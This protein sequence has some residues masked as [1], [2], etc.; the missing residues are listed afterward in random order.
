MLTFV[1]SNELWVCHCLHPVIQCSHPN[2]RYTIILEHRE[3]ENLGLFT[4]C[5]RNMMLV[6]R[7][8]VSHE[9]VPSFASLLENKIKWFTCIYRTTLLLNFSCTSAGA[10]WLFAQYAWKNSSVTFGSFLM[11]IVILSNFPSGVGAGPDGLIEEPM[12][13]LLAE[14]KVVVSA[15]TSSSQCTYSCIWLDM[16]GFHAPPKAR[17][18]SLQKTGSIR[19]MVT[20]HDS[21]VGW[22]SS[23]QFSIDRI[24]GSSA[25]VVLQRPWNHHHANWN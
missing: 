21:R 14:D 7:R 9:P 4:I 5:R 11:Y 1:L 17:D 16:L 22:P 23:R 25:G 2:F 20:G 18:L 3:P 12:L 10:I 6:S 24:L 15:G 8:F 13:L 19:E